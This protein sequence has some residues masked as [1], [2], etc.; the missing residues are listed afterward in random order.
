[1]KKSRAGN[2]PKV[3]AHL[4]KLAALKTSSTGTTSAD[5][6][7]VAET[8]RHRPILI[9]QTPRGWAIR[10]EGGGTQPFAGHY[11]TRWEFARRVVNS[12]VAENSY[13][14]R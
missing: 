10:L 14:P 2:S 13:G 3:A 4:A 7:V 1:M 6:C 9:E 8:K 5:P 12:W 11:F